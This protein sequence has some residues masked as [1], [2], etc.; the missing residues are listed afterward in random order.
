M[1][2]KNRYFNDPR[3]FVLD[4]GKTDKKKS[5]YI[6]LMFVIGITAVWIL[7][8]MVNQ[9]SSRTGWIVFLYLFTYLP[10]IYAFFGVAVYWESGIVMSCLQYQQGLV[11]IRRSLLAVLVMDVLGIVA[12]LIYIILYRMEIHV[13]PELSY[14]LLHLPV[15]ALAIIY[16]RYYDR[17]YAPKLREMQHR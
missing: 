6:N 17:T 9:D 15:I 1:I 2:N 12:E 3:V 11:R 4:M 16:G 14:L 10:L 5:S 8:G 7:A 13:I